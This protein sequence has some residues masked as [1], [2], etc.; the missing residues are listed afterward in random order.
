MFFIR[1]NRTTLNVI[2]HI[3]YVSLLVLVVK[4]ATSFG[5]L[6][7]LYTVTGSSAKRLAA[8]P[9]IRDK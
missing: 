4:F 9:G 1:H 6:N 7:I 8:C 3:N 5:S 2:I